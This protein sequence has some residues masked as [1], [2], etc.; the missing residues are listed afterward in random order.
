MSAD[1]RAK[2]VKAMGHLGLGG[3]LGKVVSLAS[4]LVMARLLSPADY[5]LMAMAMTLVGFVGFFNEVGIGAAIVQKKELG[6]A[7]VNGCF[8]FS[9]LASIVLFAATALLSAAPPPAFFG[10][11]GC[12]R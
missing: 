2:T 12:S 5:G 1:L 3:A 6:Q 4:T 11:P 10:N 7:E 9:I 8:A